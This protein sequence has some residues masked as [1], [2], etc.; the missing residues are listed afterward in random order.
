MATLALSAV[1]AAA[2]SALLPGGF[3]LLGATLTG[4][5]IGR[6][7]GGI[8]GAYI[9]QALFGASGQDVVRDGPRLADLNVTAS[10]EGADIPRVYGRARLG[11]QIIW[12]T[13]FEEEAATTSA[14]GSG[15]GLNTSGGA[16]T[17]NYRYYANFAVALC[18][19]EITRLGRVWADGDELTL[20]DYAYRVYPGSATQMPDSLIEATEGAGNAPAYRGLAYVVFERLPLADFGNRVPQLNFEVFRAVDEFEGQ[21][22]GVTL[23]PAA[24][25]FAYH[26]DEVRVDA[27]GGVSY[28]ENRHTTLAASDFAASMDQLEETLPNCG[29]VSVFSA[30]FGDDLRCGEC[31]IRPKV[32]SAAKGV[33]TTPIAWEAAG[34]TR[35]TAETVSDHDGHP[36]YG[37]TPSDM[38]VIAAIQDLAARGFDVLFT[39]FLLMDVPEANGRADPYTGASDQPAYP[40]RGRIT[41]DPAPGA[42]GSPDKTA[43]ATTQVDAFSGTVTAADFS[44][45]GETVAYSGPDEWSYSRFI[46]HCAALCRAAGGVAGFI[47]GSEMRGLGWVRD[48]TSS[49]PFVA[50]LIALAA[51]VK[52]LL[53]DAKVTYAADWSEYFGHQP[54]DGSGDVHFHL[55]PLWSDANIDAIG[56]D[57]YWPLTDWRDGT[58]HLDYQAG[59]RFIHDLAYL[60]GNIEGGEGY[61]WYYTAS[62]KF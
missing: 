17:T 48:G 46:L 29:A 19:G 53:P 62:H 8:A 36:A 37:G 4:A 25:E 13:R 26:P 11:G 2:G 40:W 15:K 30:W 27:G 58:D 39:P 34:L 59:V 18:E 33:G 38:T 41:C 10:T 14:G 9:D 21:V 24:G 49:Y 5:A 44:I 12:A 16:S 47:I 32:D 20:S 1:G 61:D 50:K 31:T 7:V 43:A 28:S 51:E 45:S 35:A 22:R 52:A 55:D 56:I 42:S 60:K 6:A 23:I 57:V 3:S 54:T